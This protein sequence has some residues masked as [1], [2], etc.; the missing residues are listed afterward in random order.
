MKI[1]N[2]ETK[3]TKTGKDYLSFQYDDKKLNYFDTANFWSIQNAFKDNMDI[4]IITQK[5]GK[6]WNVV[7]VAGVSAPQASAPKRTTPIGRMV[8]EKNER[9]EKSMDRKENSILRAALMRDAAL[10]SVETWI[11]FSGDTDVEM[12]K[13]A[14]QYWEKYFRGLYIGEENEE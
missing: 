5:E 10:F 1:I 3:Q 9:I 8:A 12:L 2:L 6:F 4:E 11:Q 7:S 14:R 13:N